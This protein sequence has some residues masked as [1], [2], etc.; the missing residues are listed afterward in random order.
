MAAR[1]R[2]TCEVK[3]EVDADAGDAGSRSNSSAATNN[4]TPPAEVAKNTSRHPC[5]AI[6]CDN[7][8]P[9]MAVPSMPTAVTLLERNAKRAGGNQ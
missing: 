2:R 8:T 7:A 1:L 4:P 5:T 3:W 9:P 6:T